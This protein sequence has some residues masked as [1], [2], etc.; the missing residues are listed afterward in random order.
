MIELRLDK[1]VKLAPAFV[2]V[3]TN[4]CR[5]WFTV[6]DRNR[7]LTCFSGLLDVELVGDMEEVW[8]D[9]S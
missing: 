3:T 7:V 4:A 6:F 5:K 2:L 1:S 9:E 8:V